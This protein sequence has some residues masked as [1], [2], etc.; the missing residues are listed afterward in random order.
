MFQS[1]AHLTREGSPTGIILSKVM[2]AAE[3]VPHLQA[4][5]ALLI[6]SRKKLQH[7]SNQPIHL[8]R[9]AA[10]RQLLVSAMQP[11]QSTRQ[12]VMELL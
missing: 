6:N 12:L 5:Y 1:I 8:L 11:L 3:N 9:F 2:L 7:H 10:V 4:R